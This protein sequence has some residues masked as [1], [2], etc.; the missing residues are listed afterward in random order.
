MQTTEWVAVFRQMGA[1]GAVCL[2]FGL[3]IWKVFLPMMKETVS[4]ARK[5]RDYVRQ[6]RE[7]EVKQFL[8]SSK[9][10]DERFLESLKLR[11]EK[12]ERA[13]DEVARAIR[14]R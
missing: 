13:L 4:D 3:I 8:E 7:Q 2:F 1:V 11:D 5:E 12:T 10:R 9:A 14:E 6:L